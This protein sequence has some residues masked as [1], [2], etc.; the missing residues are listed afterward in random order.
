MES[1]NEIQKSMLDKKVEL[2]DLQGLNVLTVEEELAVGSPSS[3]SKVAIWRLIFYVVASVIW[4]WKEKWSL[5]R[6]EIVRKVEANRPHTEAW[7]KSKAL[8]FQWG[9]EL[10]DSDEYAV[11]DTTKQI[12]KQVAIVESDR[13]L[14]VKIATLNGDVLAPL[15]EEDQVNAFRAYMNKVK[16][17]GTQLL[18]INEDA[19][20]LRLA[21][22]YYY[23]PQLVGSDGVAFTSGINV[24]QTAVNQ[25]LNS[26]EFNGR[27]ELNKLI[28]YL[29]KA[30]GYKDVK[31]TF[32][33]FKAG[34][35]TSYTA[36]DRAYQPLSGY[37]KL[38]QLDVTYYGVV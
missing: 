2:E 10:V 22:E 34:I 25:Y 20:R 32:A 16:D 9:D 14:I 15:P 24:V 28:D 3:T 7:Y 6:T 12:V 1:I 11:I 38:E 5:F 27:F 19:D 37:M 31:I 33:G 13:R 23:D 30:I 21:L 8:A 35:S 36:I 26:V 4:A 29:Q 18:V 17:A